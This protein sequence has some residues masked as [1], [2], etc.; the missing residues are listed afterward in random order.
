MDA[1]LFAKAAAK[2]H[3]P[4]CPRKV[5]VLLNFAEPHKGVP[6]QPRSEK[7]VCR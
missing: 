3:V 5:E 6:R 1:N 4:M 7:F 2:K